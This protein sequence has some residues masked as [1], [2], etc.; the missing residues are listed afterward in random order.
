MLHVI[1]E[2]NGF[3]C[4]DVHAYCH[5]KYLGMYHPDNELIYLNVL[6]NDRNNWST[7]L[8]EQCEAELKS[9]L[10][11]D[12]SSLVSI[13]GKLAVC[14]IPR[15]K[16]EASYAFSQM[17][18]KRAISAAAKSNPELEDGTDYVVRHTDT[19]CTHLARW[20]N[21]G[22]GEMPR[23]GLMRDTCSFSPNIKGKSLLLVDDIFTPGCGIDDDGIQALFDAGADSVV[24]YAVGMARGSGQGFRLCA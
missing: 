16:R 14:G 1:L 19:K 6:K 17:G 18:L 21:G 3:L 13:Y 7:E 4:H 15:S 10:T 5:D 20:G 12:F 11:A 22:A 9:V 23:P 24:F 8:V 2:K